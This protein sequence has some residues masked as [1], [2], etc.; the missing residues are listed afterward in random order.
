MRYEGSCHCGRIAFEVEGEFSSGLACNCSYCRRRGTIF[1]FVPRGELVLTTP[2]E[3]LST[4]RFN[5]QTM[6]HRFCAACGVGPFSEV[7]APDGTAMTAIN[8]RCVPAID[9]ATLEISQYDGA[10]R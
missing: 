10:S 9:L 3:N 6:E 4:Y 2:E 5:T 1:A 7:T 8:L